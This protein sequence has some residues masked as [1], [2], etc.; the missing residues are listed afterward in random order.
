MDLT[1]GVDEHQRGDLEDP[2][3]PPHLTNLLTLSP[4][5]GRTID[6]RLAALLESIREWDWRAGTGPHVPVPPVVPISKATPPAPTRTPPPPPPVA[7]ALRTIP[8]A[9]AR[10][11]SMGRHA[12]RARPAAPVTRVQPDPP[13]A[14]PQLRVLPTDPPPRAPSPNWALG[15]VPPVRTEPPDP[16]GPPPTPPDVTLARRPGWNTDAMLNTDGLQS[17]PPTGFQAP[18]PRPATAIPLPPIRLLPTEPDADL[19]TARETPAAAVPAVQPS[20]DETDDVA[21]TVEETSADVPPK[22]A[23]ATS[24]K[25]PKNF[26]KLV[27][28]LVTIVA[29]VAIVAI[30]RTSAENPSS[31]SLTPTSVTQKK[32]TPATSAPTP[33]V[34]VSS[35]VSSA[36]TTASLNLNAANA[37]VAQELAG[38]ASQSVS[39]V[40]LEVA[41]YVK[42]LN[43]FNFQTHFLAWPANLQ[44]PSQDLTLRTNQLITYLSSI[45]T[46]TP[47]TL[48]S[49]FAQFHSLA[50]YTQEEDN[51]LRNDLGMSPTT[52]Y[53]TK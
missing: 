52:S 51:V 21:P 44:V 7:P 37:T 42:A 4:D 43:I 25:W 45:S 39:Q 26:G 27:L 36:F 1:E 50:R 29:V 11:T 14:T 30:I 10:P 41:P 24:Y 23:V 46:T 32:T 9:P 48:T 8:P 18:P 47:A 22:E 49:W 33:K 34:A 35:A 19:E 6:D 31:G 17:D 5:T 28:V 13:M 16:W 53:P 38:G 40:A 20:P 15:A 3:L 12:A 2:S